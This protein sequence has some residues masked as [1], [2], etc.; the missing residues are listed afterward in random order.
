MIASSYMPSFLKRVY[1]LHS[2]MVTFNINPA[3]CIESV[4]LTAV[5]ILV[6]FRSVKS[7][8]CFFATE[9]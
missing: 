1:H 2:K 9:M 5:V 3:R 8:I 6:T 4:L 7:K